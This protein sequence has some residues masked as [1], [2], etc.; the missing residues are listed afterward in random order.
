[1]YFDQILIRDV[2]YVSANIFYVF[3][4]D[5][6]FIL[7]NLYTTMMCDAHTESRVTDYINMLQERCIDGVLLHHLAIT[8]AMASLILCLVSSFT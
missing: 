6:F 8:E 2:I 7:V 3:M 4:I 1:M 5:H